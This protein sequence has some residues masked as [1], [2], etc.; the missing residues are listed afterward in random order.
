MLPQF[1]KIS[2]LQNLLTQLELTQKN[3]QKTVR[4]SSI[5]FVVRNLHCQGE[6]F[7]ECQQGML[8]YIYLNI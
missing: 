2:I 6:I 4:K 8:H 7:L 1:V 3:R 5:T